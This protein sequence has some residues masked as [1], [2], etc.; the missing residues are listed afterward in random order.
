MSWRSGREP[1]RPWS[2][3]ARLTAWYAGSAFALVLAAT[4]VLY[5]ALV[6]NLDRE[7]AQELGGQVRVLRAVLRGGPADP[8]SVRREAEWA[9]AA[10]QAG[11]VHVRILDAAGGIV[12]E[13][14]GM[15]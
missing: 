3:A 15:A 11:P 7:D 14:P 12:A 1:R 13:T 9:W 5:W 2:L 8:A 10:R 6:Q 4:A